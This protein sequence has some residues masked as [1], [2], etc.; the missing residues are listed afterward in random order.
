MPLADHDAP[1][2]PAVGVGWRHPHYAQ[3]LETQP[4]LDFLEVHSENFFAQ[5]GAALAVLAQG[6]AHYPISLHGVGLSLGSAAGLDD[7]HLDQLA[8]LVQRIEP[9][10]VSDHAAFARGH[11]QGRMV[12]ASDLL[13]LP[14]TAEA[15]QVLC[16]H[17]QQVQDRLQR[18]FMV[19]NLSAYL[20]WQVPP[21]EAAWEEA[22]FLTELA[23]RTGCELLVDVNNIY[24]NALNVQ[25]AGGMADPVQACRAWL[26]AI[27]AEAV[28]ELHLAGH[29]HV[30]DDHGDIVIDDH[31]SRVCDP[32]WDLYHHAVQRFG[33]VP[34]L[35]EWDTDIPALDV[36]L[37]EAARA[38]GVAQDAL[39]GVSA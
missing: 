1:G 30:R 19:E 17:V 35:V 24:V 34:T 20:R 10:R 13:P 25:K 36:L 29:R 4:A 6:R 5:G 32:V 33:A 2:A 18:P 31:G 14:F 7:W 28:G 22:A 12:H 3:L 15:L 16:A 9:I 39:Q 11:F 8:Q 27:P 37:D 38:R 23:R 21:E 26:D